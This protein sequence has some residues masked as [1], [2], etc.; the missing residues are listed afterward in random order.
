MRWLTSA[1]R[2]ASYFQLERSIDNINYVPVGQLSRQGE[3]QNANYSF[4]DNIAGYNERLIYYRLRI[5][6]INGNTTFSKIVAVSANLSN[7]PTFAVAPNPVKDQAQL[8][9]TSNADANL[10]IRIYSASGRLVHSVSSSIFKG[11]SLVTIPE[12]QTWPRGIY[13][14]RANIGG[15]MLTQKMTLVK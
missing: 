11:S 1:N 6:D 10:D 13:V 7:S 4:N 12:A 5:V 14:V 9:F 15:E 2:S 3:Q 8:V